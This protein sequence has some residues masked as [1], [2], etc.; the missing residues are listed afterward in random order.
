VWS[1]SLQPI[2]EAVPH[3]AL[4]LDPGASIVEA[5]KWASYA[6]LVHVGAVLSARGGGDKVLVAVFV[7]CWLVALASL[8]HVLLSATTVWGVYTP[9]HKIPPSHMG[10]L[11]NT[12]TL[13]GYMNLGVFIGLGLL[14]RRRPTLPRPVLGGRA[15]DHPRGVDPDR[16]AR[17][18]GRPRTRA[19]RLHRRRAR[20]DPS[21]ARAGHV[22]G[23]VVA[24]T[25][26]PLAVAAALV[27]FSA[28]SVFWGE[29]LSQDQI[30]LRIPGWVR[31]MIED[32]W[33]FGVGRGAF[34]TTFTAYAPPAGQHA[35]FTHPENFV[36]QWAAEW[37]VPLALAMMAAFAWILRPT[38]VGFG[39][40]TSATGAW[41][42]L[43]VFFLQNLVDLGTELFGVGAT[44]AVVIGVLCGQVRGRSREA[45][46]RASRGQQLALRAA[47]AAALA[48]VPWTAA[49]GMTPVERDR[50]ELN[51]IVSELNRG[52]KTQE[53]IDVA[54]AAVVERVRRHPADYY[55]PLMG[56]VTARAAGDRPIPWI[57]RALERGPKVGRVHLL[58]GEVLIDYGVVDQALLELRFAAEYEVSLAFYAASAA[59]RSTRDPDRL[60]AAVPDGIAGTPMLDALAAA[61]AAPADVTARERMDLE[62]LARD[63]A[64]LPPRKRLIATRLTALPSAGPPCEDPDVCLE[65]LEAH[66]D[67]LALYDRETTCSAVTRAHVA[68]HRGEMAEADAI[69]AHGCR[70]REERAECLRLHAETLSTLGETERLEDVLNG[71]VAA[72]CPG[73]KLC[74]EAHGWV[75]GLRT[76]R[77]EPLQAL[78]ALRKAAR[79]EPTL[80]RWR[81]VADSAET[82]GSHG[83]T[84]EALK[85]LRELDP[86][87][88]GVADRL[89]RVQSASDHP[90]P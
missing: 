61:L 14:V 79:A 1:R 68:L 29:L 87:D 49:R 17:R 83:V 77:G 70:A 12:N 54:Y 90:T 66:A 41:V 72:S 9:W 65:E 86:A 76:R 22:H 37:G 75:A 51:A 42:G 10:P 46:S 35:V 67:A 34:A 84:L 62:A 47:F 19:H 31:P 2:G 11:L 63:P 40:S 59:L 21:T 57:Q 27:L 13:A 80:D 89:K 30:K 88:A 6:A 73:A 26:V 25:S 23:W 50:F 18:A 4:S 82:M 39:K 32:H 69:L 38:N 78:E 48:L 3:G 8:G 15:R 20:D 44:V 71:L 64:L 55:M 7:S 36:V 56:A 85:R 5:L 53:K 43:A 81:R 16:V 33:W 24:L 28:D 60:M 52:P 58:L 45:R 74:A